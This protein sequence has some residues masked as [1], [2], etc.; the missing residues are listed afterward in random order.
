MILKRILSLL[1]VIAI[2][3]GF[4]RLFHPPQLI[5]NIEQAPEIIQKAMDITLIN[6]GMVM[7]G[8]LMI[9]IALFIKR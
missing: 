4:Y 7:I 6:M 2:I 9:L 8:G 1:G 5:D 3:V